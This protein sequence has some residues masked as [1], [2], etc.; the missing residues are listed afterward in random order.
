MAS[1][2]SAINTLQIPTGIDVMPCGV[3][4]ADIKE[5]D[6]TNCYAK[7]NIV[8]NICGNNVGKNNSISQLDI[9]ANTNDDTKIEALAK[10]INKILPADYELR[11]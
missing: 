10:S 6:L 3:F 7:Y 8:K 9:F 4:Y 2:K 5:Y 1:L 11:T